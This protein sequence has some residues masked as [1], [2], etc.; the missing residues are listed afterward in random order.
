MAARTR[1]RS[2]SPIEV[3]APRIPPALAVDHISVVVEDGQAV[4]KAGTN[5]GVWAHLTM[6]PALARALAMQTERITRPAR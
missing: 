5:T 6:S 1:T 4:I 3:P 2:I